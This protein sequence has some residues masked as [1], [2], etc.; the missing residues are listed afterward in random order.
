MIFGTV[1]SGNQTLHLK[2]SRTTDRG[3]VLC[4]PDT[5]G[6]SLMHVFSYRTVFYLLYYLFHLR[7]IILLFGLLS[8]LLFIFVSVKLARMKESNPLQECRNPTH[9]EYAGNSLR[10]CRKHTASMQEP[11]CEYAGISLRV[12]RK[13]T[14]SM[15]EPHCEYAGISLRV[16]R[17]Q[18]HFK[19]AGI[20][21][22]ASMQEPHCEYAGIELT[23][24]RQELNSLRV[25]QEP[26]SLRVGRN[27]AHC[28][29][30]GMVNKGSPRGE[31]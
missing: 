6:L 17:N 18:A 12:C 21:R 10:V 14:A 30:A 16:C 23:A 13:H 26:T 1:G 8:L 27:Q 11:H 4:F 24:S 15:Q 2:I 5:P 31:D 29:Y 20:L 25:L 19:F 28:E 9:C 22:T 7:D 3:L